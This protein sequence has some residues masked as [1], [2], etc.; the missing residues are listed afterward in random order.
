MYG[1]AVTT[2]GAEG[3]AMTGSERRCPTCGAL[4]VDEV[5][6]NDAHTGTAVPVWQCEQQH[7][8]LQSRMHGLIPIDPGATPR[9]EATTTVEDVSERA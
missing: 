7:W 9:E 4:L 6:V 1:E 3:E 2:D 8:W 5:R